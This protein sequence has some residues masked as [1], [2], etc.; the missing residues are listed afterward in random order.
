[1]KSVFRP[2][3]QSAAAS[4]YGSVLDEIIGVSIQSQKG[5]DPSGL[6]YRE[7]INKKKKQIAAWYEYFCFL[8]LFA[9][10]YFIYFYSKF[11]RIFLF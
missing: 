7:T 3:S 1:M 6:R 2:D 11:C 10:F 4:L 5:A 8:G 9:F